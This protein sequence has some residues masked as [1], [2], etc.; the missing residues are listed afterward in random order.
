MDNKVCPFCKTT[1]C[2]EG[3]LI[4]HKPVRFRPEH[5]KFFTLKSKVD[6]KAFLCQNCGQIS[7]SCNIED[8]KALTSEH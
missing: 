1:N 3:S 6:A 5:L 7:I 4:G 8:A 2:I